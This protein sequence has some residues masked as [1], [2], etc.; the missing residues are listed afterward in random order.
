ML[1][2]IKAFALTVFSSCSAPTNCREM[3]R[4]IP[5]FGSGLLDSLKLHD[6]LIFFMESKT[7]RMRTLSCFV[8]NVLIFAGR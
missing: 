1:T 6:T 8:L 2:S 5:S 3:Q 4:V 7:I